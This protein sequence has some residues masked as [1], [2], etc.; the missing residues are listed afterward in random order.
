MVS[1]E[2]D[3]RIRYVLNGKINGINDGEGDG[4]VSIKLILTY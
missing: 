1:G 2:D 3:W 4:N